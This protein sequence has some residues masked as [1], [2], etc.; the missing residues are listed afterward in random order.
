MHRVREYDKER[1]PSE[2][3][4]DDLEPINPMIPTNPTLETFHRRVAAPCV[5]LAALLC[6]TGLCWLT[7]PPH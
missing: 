7:E 6:C 1:G 4:V 2:A 5:M 3:Q